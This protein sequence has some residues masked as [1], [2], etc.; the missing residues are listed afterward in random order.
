MGDIEREACSKLSQ[1]EGTVKEH[2]SVREKNLSNDLVNLLEFI[3]RARDEGKWD[4][5]RLKFY[6]ISPENLLGS[7]YQNA[8]VFF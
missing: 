3:R 4:A 8:L 1:L 6:C 2:H 5:D 7:N